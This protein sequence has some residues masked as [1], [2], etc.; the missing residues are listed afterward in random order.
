MKSIE[1]KLSEAY[2]ANFDIIAEGFPAR[3]N[4]ARGEYMEDFMLAGLPSAHDERFLQSDMQALLG[5][6]EREMYFARPRLSEHL[7]GGHSSDGDAA[8]FEE[9]SGIKSIVFENGFL[10]PGSSV[11]GVFCGSL[12]DALSGP[13]NSMFHVEQSEQERAIS[14]TGAGLSAKGWHRKA[15]VDILPDIRMANARSSTEARTSPHSGGAGKVNEGSFLNE[16]EI[17]ATSPTEANASVDRLTSQDTASETIFAAYNSLA[18]NRGDALTALNSAFMQDGALVWIPAGVRLAEP[19]L[20]D[21]RFL[22]DEEALMSFG[23]TLIV[24]G[25]GAEADISILYRTG[26]NTRFLIDFVREIVVGKGAHL[27][28]SECALMGPGS[29]LLLNGYMKQHSNSLTNRVFTALGTGFSRLSLQ[30]DLAEEHADAEMHG[31]YISSNHAHS[32]IELRLN[33]LAPDCRSRQLVKGIATDEATG[34]FSGMVYVARDAQR[35]D[36]AQQNRN[37]Q[38]TDTAKIYTRPQLE[39][40]ADDVKCGHGATIGRLDE[41]A[42]YYMRQRGVGEGEARKMQMQGFAEDVINHCSSTIFRDFV[43]AKAQKLIADF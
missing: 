33:H 29:S 25:E 26:G 32:D 9:L 22:S 20:L 41:E 17:Q 6:E 28:F 19:L 13:F 40:Y 14:S 3:L 5:A 21:F 8:V 24:I 15:E 31:L 4:A 36:A 1:H 7:A 38:L 18:D 10:A 16:R 43:A 30:T 42:I 2:T 39:I 27:R 11:E 23:R 12:R 35:T 37:L 34:V